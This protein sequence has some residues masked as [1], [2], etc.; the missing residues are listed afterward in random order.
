[1]SS[2]VSGSRPQSRLAPA[3]RLEDRAS[4][5]PRRLGWGVFLLALAVYLVTANG[6]LLGQDQ[7]SFYQVAQAIAVDHTFAIAPSD[8]GV[9]G[10]SGYLGRDGRRYSGY[11]PGWSVALAPL[12]L[13][14]RALS[15][16]MVTLRPHFPWPADNS[17]DLGSRFLVSYANVFITAAS[18]ALLAL[19]VFR[20]GYSAAA[21]AFVALTFAFATPAWAHA[22]ILFVE[23]LQGLLVLLAVLLLLR[24]RSSSALLGGTS[25][26]LAILVKSTSIVALPGLLLLPD[27]DG[28]LLWRTP[29]RAALVLGP[30]ALGVALYGLYNFLC[31]GNPLQTG[32][33]MAGSVGLHIDNPFRSLYGLTLSSGR[34]ILWFAPP[35]LAGL[36]GYRR[37]FRR[38]QT[39]SLAFAVLAGLWRRFHAV[40]GSGDVGWDSGWGWGPRYLL[41][42]LPFALVPLAEW[43]QVPRVRPALLALVLLGVG[44]QVP[45]VTV[46]FMASGMRGLLAFRQHCSSCD[47][48][49][50]ANWRDFVPAGSELTSSTEMLLSGKVDLAWITFWGTWVVPVTALLVAASATAGVAALSDAL[51]LHCPHAT[52]GGSLHNRPV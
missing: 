10:G 38:C 12:V 29:R 4:S 35:I 47:N 48:T 5:T 30:V 24:C 22:R 17:A 33:S 20:L 8:P 31:F 13:Y 7:E 28:R 41:V 42:A 18:T 15:G 19:L 9:V 50:F 43:W 39:V 44:I 21:S 49:A 51:G 45:G 2:S 27:S 11:A 6:H 34:G 52:E 1:V 46:D 23:P 26:A 25:M 32:Y 37:F 3:P 40:V 14:G 16:L 36:L